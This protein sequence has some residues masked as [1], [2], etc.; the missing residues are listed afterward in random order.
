M[1][2]I[3]LARHGET[4][5]NVEEIFRG[6]I[7][8]ELNETGRRQA[9]LLAGHLLDINIEAVYSSPLSRALETAEAIAGRRRLEVDV[10]AGLMDLDFGEWQGLSRREV[11]ERYPAL[12]EEWLNHPERVRFPAGGSLSAVRERATGLIDELIGKHTG[13][14]VLVSH[15]VVNKVLICALLGLDD[16]HFWNI[17]QD[18]CA[19]TT[20]DYEQG[21]FVLAGHNQTSYLKSIPKIPPV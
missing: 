20:F 6:R 5:W 11:A 8:V 7:D 12:H 19:I 13:T 4:A 1:K 18:T 17:S 15:R 2:K 3:I 14:L 9:Q 21:R 16:S 10:S